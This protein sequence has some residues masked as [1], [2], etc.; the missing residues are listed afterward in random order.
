MRVGAH[1]QPMILVEA[2]MIDDAQPSGGY[3]AIVFLLASELHRSGVH[4]SDCKL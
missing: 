2:V 4:A 1:G 3:E